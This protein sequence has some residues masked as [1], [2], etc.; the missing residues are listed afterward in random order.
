[1]AM[2]GLRLLPFSYAVRQVLSLVPCAVTVHG[3]TTVGV[4]ETPLPVKT[5]GRNM[6]RSLSV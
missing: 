3:A 6:D 5:Q 4:V 1:M 2:A